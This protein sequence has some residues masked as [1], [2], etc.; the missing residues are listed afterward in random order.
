V[1][2]KVDG[3]YAPEHSTGIIW[4][5]ADIAIRWPIAA[6]NA[7]LSESDGKLSRF[8]DFQ[9]SF[10]PIMT[11]RFIM[12]G[13]RASAPYPGT[14]LDAARKFLPRVCA[15]PSVVSRHAHPHSRQNS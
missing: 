2:Y 5:D 15:R 4:N 9:S 3:Y 10:Y 8:G 11:K 12:T 13:G 7:Y 1:A 6:N 14:Q